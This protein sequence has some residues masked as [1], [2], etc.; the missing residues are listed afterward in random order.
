V[1]HCFVVLKPGR[2]P[3]DSLRSELIDRVAL[4]LGKSFAPDKI[5]FVEELPK[6][7]S[8]KIL[9]RL[10]RKVAL[11]E[12]PGDLSSVENVAALAAIRRSI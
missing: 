7:R 1:I 6:T 9:R 5:Q 8:G 2:E 12:D 3:A 4:A 11:D 10:I